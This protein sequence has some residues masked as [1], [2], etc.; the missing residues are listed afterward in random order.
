MTYGV[1]GN[2]LRPRMK[3]PG[4]V[5]R[6]GVMRRLSCVL[7]DD[8][9]L[10]EIRVTPVYRNRQSTNNFWPKRCCARSGAHRPRCQ[11]ATSISAC[12]AFSF[13]QPG[14][15]RASTYYLTA[16]CGTASASACGGP[17]PACFFDPSWT[18]TPR[19]I[20]GTHPPST[21]HVTIHAPLTWTSILS[22]LRDSPVYELL[23]FPVCVLLN[24]T[25]SCRSA[26]ARVSPDS[27][28]TASLC[29]LAT[30]SFH[31][32]GRPLWRRSSPSG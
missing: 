4:A 10:Y 14:P 15:Q 11:R 24:K 26:A 23:N 28:G 32:P 19:S 30:R 17:R 12:F 6:P 8:V 29:A 9:L 5:S 1:R 13:W 27:P 3:K 21:F 18:R 25:W 2:A 7:L 22:C 31:W 16:T 20:A